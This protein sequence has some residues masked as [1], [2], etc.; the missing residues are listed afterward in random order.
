MDFGNSRPKQTESW[1][2]LSLLTD[3]AC[4]TSIKSPLKTSETFFSPKKNRTDSA[5]SSPSSIPATPLDMKANERTRLPGVFSSSRTLNLT[6]PEDRPGNNLQVNGKPYSLVDSTR[7]RVNSAN[8]LDNF[9]RLTPEK[10]DFSNVQYGNLSVTPQA[11]PFDLL[12]AAGSNLPTPPPLA[13]QLEQGA[14]VQAVKSSVKLNL[15]E[16][17]TAASADLDAVFRVSQDSDS[18]DSDFHVSQNMDIEEDIVNDSQDS[19]TVQETDLDH[20]KVQENEKEKE[21]TLH[22][23]WRPRRKKVKPTWTLRACLGRARSQ[24]SGFAEDPLF[25]LSD[26][27]SQTQS[28]LKKAL[29]FDENSSLLFV[30][31]RGA[32]KSFLLK[33]CLQMVATEEK[34]PLHKCFRVVTLNGLVHS[35][36]VIVLREITRQLSSSAAAEDE[37]FRAMASVKGSFC[38]H[39]NFLFDT[40]KDEKHSGGAPVVFVL[41]E[42]HAFVSH[43]KQTV[44]YNLLDMT[45]S[46]NS[47]MVVVGM[48]RR[49]DIVSQMEKRIRSRFDNR[50]VLFPLLDFESLNELLR[51]KLRV[52]SES[53]SSNEAVSK[54]NASVDH[55][56]ADSRR[57]LHHHHNMGHSTG[58]FMRVLE[59]SLA[60]LAF[61][62]SPLLSSQNLQN[63]AGS[64]VVDM[65]SELFYT[66]STLELTLLLAMMH[67]ETLGMDRYNFKMA[68]DAVETHRQMVDK[69]S[70]EVALKA[71]EHL[72]D[73]NLI[74][75]TLSGKKCGSGENS[76]SID[77]EFRFVR[78][79]LSHEQIRD[80]VKKGKV[81]C[82]THL[83]QWAL[84]EQ[85]AS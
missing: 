24:V 13:L 55:A 36:D 70:K 72:L 74:A 65:T 35:N 44:L 9:E 71:F 29:L 37:V 50:Q 4:K 61:S 26:Q 38:D 79:K 6:C 58:W 40:L 76:K 51:Y 46:N 12:S 16:K 20:Q 23:W 5:F 85:Y 75:K 80:A 1:S 3:Y 28:L 49:Y 73:L 48:T 8:K 66:V 21:K 7:K 25:G 56:I 32:G 17:N 41:E 31:E 62:T 27:F 67:L 52:S 54:W 63:A 14:A 64:L 34:L 18:Q 78:L 22:K 39:L 42:F 81:R 82:P 60:A 10:T 77:K 2:S 47:K 11:L 53:A 57:A 15:N 30:G 68:F 84:Q 59:N 33:K 69:M 45:Q 43:H 83:M 19:L